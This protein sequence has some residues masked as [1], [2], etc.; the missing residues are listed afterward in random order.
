[1][2]IYV[3][4]VEQ[5]EKYVCSAKKALIKKLV[6]QI[7]IHTWIVKLIIVVI[8]MLT[9][10]FVSKIDVQLV[11]LVG[12]QLLTVRNHLKI[13]RLSNVIY[14]IVIFADHR[15]VS[16]LLTIVLNAKVKFL[17]PKLIVLILYKKC[18]VK[19]ISVVT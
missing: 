6:V 8:L 1:M 7:L 2:G 12:T 4:N 17:T 5:M 14:Q 3:I 9:V 10:L 15:L 13:T 16:L 18:L 11:I 19:S